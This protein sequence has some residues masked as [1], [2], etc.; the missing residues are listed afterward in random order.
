M[1]K[2][3]LKA[4]EALNKDEMLVSAN[5]RF[6]LIMQGDGNVVLY[7]KKP[8]EKDFWKTGKRGGGTQVIWTARTHG[9]CRIMMQGDGNLVVT[10]L[11]WKKAVWASGTG[12]KGNS[13]SMLVMQNDGNAVISSDG[14]VIW[15]SGSRRENDDS[16]S[17]EEEPAPPKPNPAPVQAQPAKPL[18]R[19]SWGI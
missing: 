15:M 12:G 19:V 16:D 9:D 2:D 8:S 10:D 1:A 6:H 11:S 4:G 3:R 13:S 17:G 7:D 18:V 5:N 14:V